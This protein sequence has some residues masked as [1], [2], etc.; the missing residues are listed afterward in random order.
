[1]YKKIISR[2]LKARIKKSKRDLDKNLK[3]FFEWVKGAE[4]VELKEC[5]TEKDPV[6]PELNNE[7][8][9]VMEGKF[10]VLSIKTKYMQLCVLLL[11]IK[12]QNLCTS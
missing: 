3:N 2:N 6:R 5:E 9:I 12:Y 11:L 10:M 8:E 1:V 7:L 4:L